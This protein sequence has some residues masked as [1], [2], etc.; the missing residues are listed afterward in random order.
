MAMPDFSYNLSAVHMEGQSVAALIQISGTHPGNLDLT[1]LDIAPL[2][3]T[4]LA[5]ELP[6]VPVTFLARNDTLQEMAMAA[7]AGGRL[8][9]LLQQIGGELPVV[10]RLEERFE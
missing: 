8:S 9:G 4:R 10:P 3:A 6:Q 7:V 5:V 1:M 2:Q